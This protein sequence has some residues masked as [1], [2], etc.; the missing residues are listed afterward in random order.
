MFDENEKSLMIVCDE[1]ERDF[2]NYLIQLTGQNRNNG[3]LISAAIYNEKQYKDNLPKISSQQHII[4]IGDS[5]EA[6]EQ[7]RTI[8]DTYNK[9]GM[10][11]G[12]LGKRGVLYVDKITNEWIKN[13]Y[14]QLLQY[15]KECG[16][17]LKKE[18]P[19]V[20]YMI[21][22]ALSFDR[23]EK[24]FYKE[25]I[26]IFLQD[27]GAYILGRLVVGPLIRG[28]FSTGKII[29]DTTKIFPQ[30]QFQRYVIL[31]RIFYDNYLFDFME[32]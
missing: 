23:R 25:E 16:I 14:S 20:P 3:I 28:T 26:E 5:H 4:F 30:I 22:D 11:Y 9:F 24:L 1:K 29:Y 17:E 32:K 10:H 21:I 13:E 8:V 27:P 31:Q 18:L 6:K 19:T 2:A 12:S 7:R 15:S